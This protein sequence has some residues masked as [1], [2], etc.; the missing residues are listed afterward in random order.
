MKPASPVPSHR[1]LLIVL[2]FVVWSLAFVVLYGTNAI[3]CAFGWPEGLQRN[4]LLG[5]FALHLL[6]L[7]A[8]GSWT[9]HRWRARRDDSTQPAPLLEYLGFGLTAAAFGA[10]ALTLLPTVLVT[11]CAP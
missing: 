3:G 6:A 5:L 9:W 10:T 11:M 2:G 8:L 4:V 1:M 7:S